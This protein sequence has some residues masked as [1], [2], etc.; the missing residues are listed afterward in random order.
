MSKLLKPIEWQKIVD[1]KIYDPDGWRVD[2]DELKAKNFEQ[3][4]D[5]DEFMKRALNST[6]QLG[7]TWKD[8]IN[9]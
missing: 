5:E 1:I 7:S 6:I 8:K 9:N 3:E 4:I 2:F